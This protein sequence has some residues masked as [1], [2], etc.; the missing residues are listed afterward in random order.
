MVIRLISIYRI[1]RQNECKLDST[2]SSS[3]PYD[4]VC[5][6][7]WILVDYYVCNHPPK[8]MFCKPIW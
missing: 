5:V 3:I 6:L 7:E 8:I 1:P 4:S 2:V